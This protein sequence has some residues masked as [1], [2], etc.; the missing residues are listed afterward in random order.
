MILHRRRAVARRF[1]W[2]PMRLSDG[3][4]VWLEAYWRL[5]PP[6]GPGY[7]RTMRELPEHMR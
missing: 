1:A 6:A 5:V 7:A 2:L 3:D 4:L